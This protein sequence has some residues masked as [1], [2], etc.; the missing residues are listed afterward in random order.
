MGME[1]YRSR[2]CATTWT[3]P[4]TSCSRPSTRLRPRLDRWPRP[5]L[6]SQLPSA[7]HT[8]SCPSGWRCA[9]LRP[10]RSWENTT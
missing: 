9:W 5:P 8:T 3:R 4:A 7:P 6:L 1:A 2:A 10:N